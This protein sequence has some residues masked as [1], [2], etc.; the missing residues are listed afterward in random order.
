MT[1]YDATEQA[2]KNGTVY[3]KKQILDKLT[4]L[5]GL[6][7][8]TERQVLDAVIKIIDRMEVRV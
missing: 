2:F 3:M 8:G 4:N 5:K 7:M 6:A 1:E